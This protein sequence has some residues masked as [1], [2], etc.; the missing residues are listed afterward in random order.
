M[1]IPFPP[2]AIH[3]GRQTCTTRGKHL[4]KGLFYA[5]AMVKN[6]LSKIQINFLNSLI[7]LHCLMGN[8]C[9]GVLAFYNCCTCMSSSLLEVHHQQPIGQ[10][11]AWNL[12]QQL[13]NNEKLIKKVIIILKCI[14]ISVTQAIAEL[15]FTAVSKQVLV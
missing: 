9:V 3:K 8:D 13:K 6:P 1:L 4:C 12:A 15:S 11:T 2:V 5:N 10:K 14:L 7:L